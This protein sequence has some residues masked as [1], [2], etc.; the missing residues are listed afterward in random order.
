MTQ[1]SMR[2]MLKAGAHFGHQTRYWNPKMGKYIFG[3]RNKI[4][5]IN[6]EKTMPMFHEALSFVEKQAAGKNKILFVGTKRAASKIIAEEASRAGQPY[7]DHRWLGGMLTNYKTIR[8]SIKRLRDLETQSQDGT[9]AKLTKKEALMRSRDLEKLDRSLG[10]IKDMGGLP[11]A[12]FV[13]DVE[14]ERIA[15]TEANKLGIPVIGIVDT[16]SS[17]DGVDFVI[18]GNDDAIRAIKLYAAAMADAVLRGKG[19]AGAAD[20]FVEEAAPEASEG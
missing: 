12:L 3:A 9:F 14:H 15:I 1:V 10:G 2:D 8:Q 20:E 16:N 19:N 11:D 13:I 6:L 18:P 5:I 17:P 4:H 7:V